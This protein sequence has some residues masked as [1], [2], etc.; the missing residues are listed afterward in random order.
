MLDAKTSAEPDQGRAGPPGKRQRALETR[1]QLVDAARRIFARDGFEMARLED[2]AAAAKKTRG[3]FYA[4]FRDKEDV[5]FAIFEDD[6]ARDQQRIRRPLSE[7]SSREERVAVL[8]DSLATTLRDRRRLLLNLEFKVYAVRHPRRQLRLANLVS[9]MCL[10]CAETGIDYLVPEL[11]HKDPEVKRRQA[12]QFAALVDGLAINR[13]FSPE[14]LDEKTVLHL[15]HR[16][17][18]AILELADE[19]GKRS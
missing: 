19:A 7:A 10:C 8:A 1:T 12:A 16:G 11:R 13:L 5:F 18:G 15:L 14:S 17:V 9:A 2:I 3:A 4:H 6:L